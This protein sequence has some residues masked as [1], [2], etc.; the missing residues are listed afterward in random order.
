MGVSEAGVL[1]AVPRVCYHFIE[2]L[3]MAFIG[4]HTHDPRG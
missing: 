1:R 2:K 4:T 3:P